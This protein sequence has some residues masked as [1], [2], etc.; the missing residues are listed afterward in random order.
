MASSDWAYDGQN[1]PEHWSKLYP[2]ANGNKQSPVDIKTS[3]VK[4]DTSLKPFSV[5]YNPA[6]AKEIINVGHSFHVSFE[7]NSQSG[8]LEDLSDIFPLSCQ[9]RCE[10][11]GLLSRIHPKS[12]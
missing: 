2:I 12:F 5:S 7:D 4:H 9:G 6:S 1:G 8:E 10:Q 11:W 3:E